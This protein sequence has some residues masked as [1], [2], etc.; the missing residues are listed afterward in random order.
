[1]LTFETGVQVGQALAAIK[2]HGE[3]LPKLEASHAE[4][5]QEVHSLRELV[6]RALLLAV[7][8]TAGIATNLPADKLGEVGAALLKALAK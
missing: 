1:M 7:L 6:M 5:Q 8:W 2:D 4:L 3:R